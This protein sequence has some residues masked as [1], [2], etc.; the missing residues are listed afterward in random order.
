MLITLIIILGLCLGSFATCLAYRSKYRCSLLYPHSFCETCQ[1]NLTWWQ[2]LPVLGYV[3]Q[4]GI[5][6]FATKRSH[7]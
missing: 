7:P 1:H 2:L 5:V 6:I 4:K 3:L